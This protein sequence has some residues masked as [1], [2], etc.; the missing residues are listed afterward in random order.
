MNKLEQTNKQIKEGDFSLEGPG[1][2]GKHWR[3]TG[4]TLVSPLK[5]PRF[6]MAHFDLSQCRHQAGGNQP[7]RHGFPVVSLGSPHVAA[8]PRIV[9]LSR[10]HRE[11]NV[12]LFRT[13]SA[14]LNKQQK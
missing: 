3:N 6:C 8:V 9:R 1:K 13:K 14:E 11:I 5:M 7:C 10:K 4:E 12:D 2:H